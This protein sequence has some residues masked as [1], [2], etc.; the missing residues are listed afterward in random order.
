MG[1]CLKA[2]K[3]DEA[4]DVTGVHRGE[5]GAAEGGWDERRS[6]TSAEELA[7]VLR[8]WEVMEGF[9]QGSGVKE[10][11]WF[12]GAERMGGQDVGSCVQGLGGDNGSFD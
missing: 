1:L 12:L 9:Q 5:E 6:Q 4:P 3:L 8:A 2:G 10:P 11:P 7:Y